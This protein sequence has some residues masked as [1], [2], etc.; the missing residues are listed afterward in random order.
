MPSFHFGEFHLDDARRLLFRAGQPVPL[1]PKAL[2]LLELLILERHRTVSKRELLERLWPDT[3][4]G[5]NNLSVTMSALRKALGESAAAPRYLQT[6]SRRGYRFVEVPGAEQ[7]PEAP[8][9]ASVE[10]APMSS[11]PARLRTTSV[12]GAGAAREAEPALLV[13]GRDAERARLEQRCRELLAGSGH[14]VFV[15][16]EPGIGKTTLCESFVRSLPGAEL[17]LMRGRALEQFGRG[18]AY[19]PWLEAWAGL[20]AGPDGTAARG[21][22][23]RVAPSWCREFPALFSGD[24]DG[25]ARPAL[26]VS[27]DRLIRE[28]G[29][30]LAALAAERPLLVLL[31]DLHWADAATCDLLRWVCQQGGRHRWLVVGT[32]RSVEAGLLNPP[33]AN[34]LRESLAH[35]ECEELRLAPLG[36]AHVAACVSGQFSHNDFPEDLAALLYR[37]TEGHPLFLTRLLSFLAQ[38]GDLIERD[39]VWTLGRPL[40]RLELEAPEDVR[41]MV[42]KK[43]DSLDAESR[44]ALAYASVEGGE[45]STRVL[46]ELLGADEIELEERLH[47]LGAVHRLIDVLGE[48]T[49]PDGEL[50]T[51]YRFAHA[52]YQNELYAGLVA[53]RRMQLHLRTA[54]ALARHADIEHSESERTRLAATLAVHFERGRDFARAVEFLSVAGQ[55]AH[56]LC[57]YAEDERHHQRALE[58]C[59]QLPEAERRARRPGLLL[60]LGWA[61]SD[62]G[63]SEKAERTFRELLAFAEQT[64]QPE[65]ECHALDALGSQLF[66]TGRL[67]ECRAMTQRELNLAVAHGL[68]S[69]ELLAVASLAGAEAAAGRF[70]EALRLSHE[71]M[72]VIEREGDER[73]QAILWVNLGWCAAYQGRLE[74]AD[75]AYARALER[76]RGISHIVS[77]LCMHELGWVRAARGRPSEAIELFMASV[78][79]DRL[80]NHEFAVRR[81][82]DGIGWLRRELGDLAAAE[83]HHQAAL[84]RTRRHGSR[85]TELCL[86]IELTHDALALEQLAPAEQRLAQARALLGEGDFRVLPCNVQRAELRWHQARARV[87]LAAGAGAGDDARQCAGSLLELAAQHPSHEHQIVAHEIL[88]RVALLGG[89]LDEARRALASALAVLEAHPL[90][91][92]GWRLHALSAELHGAAGAHDAAARDLTRARALIEDIASHVRDPRL[93]AC[94]RASPPVSAVLGGA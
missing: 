56:R 92:L 23:R 45:F 65:Q 89:Q 11:S 71:S 16:G 70:Q 80:H 4:V 43:L 46:A 52:L 35:R 61:Q 58:L 68:R 86:L 24:G 57:A 18:E 63:Q 41:A 38:R 64:A 8:A 39:G 51:R 32:F 12:P 48:E 76:W 21:V 20:L 17:R 31:E 34:C 26:D 59:E 47:A 27:R 81:T 88:A 25:G 66:L 3:I 93:A 50:S 54:E 14:V 83:A 78:Q 67:D 55:N 13:V 69:Q 72:A 49:W 77:A 62:S 91:F 60:S 84:E 22:L 53:R 33:L 94:F 36:P 29:D 19:L 37:K 1:V 15:T 73:T 42:R 7:S 85:F 75:D 87:S 9:D 28:M 10:P 40:D 79:L 82:P 30:A 5:D 2:E 90:P 44:T 6:L 74:Q